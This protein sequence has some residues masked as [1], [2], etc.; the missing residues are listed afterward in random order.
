M[1]FYTHKINLKIRSPCSTDKPPTF[2]VAP[3]EVHNMLRVG[4][5]ATHMGRVFS[6]KFSLEKDIG[7]AE[8]CKI[9]KNTNLLQQ[10][11]L[12]WE[13]FPSFLVNEV[14]PRYLSKF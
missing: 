8:V 2:G 1:E 9:V 11:D 6:N 13:G 12:T 14:D 5:C 7:A 3:W 10:A 4:V